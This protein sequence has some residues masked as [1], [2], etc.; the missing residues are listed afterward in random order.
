MNQAPELATLEADA[1]GDI[2]S[3]SRAMVAA[4]EQGDW[5]AV[6][7]QEQDRR[8]R[9]KRYFS[10]APVVAASAG[11]TEAVHTLVA[12]DQRVIELGKAR[13]NQIV[14][15]LRG[16]GQGSRAVRAYRQAGR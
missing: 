1:L 5:E 4:A 2:L 13:R 12:L 7:A 6:T 9:I 16:L 11:L 14:D 15:T 3:L 10:Q 8:G